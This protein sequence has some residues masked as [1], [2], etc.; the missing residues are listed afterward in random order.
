[1]N[2]LASLLKKDTI[3][4]IK[5]VF[6]IL[7][8]VFAVIFMLL[9]VFVI[10]EDIRTTGVAYIYDETKLVENFVLK[11]N[12]EV[13]KEKGEY[14]VDS[15]DEV[16]SGMTEDA[17]SIGIIITGQV[18]GK[19]GVEVLT[20]P[21]TKQALVNWVDVDME[22]LMSILHP[23][24]GIY[25]SDVYQTIQVT[26]LERGKRDMLPFNQ[27][28]LP[29][30]LFW[31]VGL[32]G[33]FAMVSIIGRERI[34]MT[35]RA[36]RLSPTPLWQFLLSKTLIILASFY[37]GPMEA[38]GWVLLFMIIMGL[39]AI[40]LLRP[41]FSPRWMMLIPSYFTLFGLDAA[42]FPDDNS[43]DIIL[44]STAVLSFLSAVMILLS[45]W[46]FS[47]RMRKEF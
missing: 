23:P 42:M 10:P 34:D 24:N 2:K 38:I 6:I 20:Q 41:S 43:S 13:D 12:P 17:S 46:I 14:Y 18:N 39:P 5:D 32:M 47:R 25:S 31:M 40:S 26:A 7:E 1:M 11:W 35:I 36:F 4:G 9:M 8:L 16:I 44:Q 45:A 29:P 15:R 22:D 3:L 21:Y 37:G 30:V 19:Y 27:R 33:L 28:L